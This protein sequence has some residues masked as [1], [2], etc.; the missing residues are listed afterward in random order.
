MKLF[1]KKVNIHGFFVCYL[2][3]CCS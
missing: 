1:N 3:M 2:Q